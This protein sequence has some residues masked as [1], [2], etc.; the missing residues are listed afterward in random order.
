MV[1]FLNGSCYF[2][3]SPNDAAKHATPM[4]MDSQNNQSGPFCTRLISEG[5]GKI[6]TQLEPFV[7][8]AH[9]IQYTAYFFFF[10]VFTN[11]F[12]TAMILVYI[13]PVYFMFSLV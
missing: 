10:Y 12:C 11:L 3:W 13:D 1:F 5:R 6:L 8:T 9:S 7:A 4:S 2:T